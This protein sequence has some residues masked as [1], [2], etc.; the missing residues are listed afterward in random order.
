MKMNGS[1]YKRKYSYSN[2]KNYAILILF[3]T[4]FFGV[5][6][7]YLN[8]MLTINGNATVHKN[9]WDVHFENI[10][11]VDGS[12]DATSEATITGDTAIDF[13]VDLALPGDFYNFTVD[14][15]NDGTIDAMLSEVL[16]TGLT[17]EQEAYVEYTVTYSDG[18]EILAKDALPSGDQDQLLVSVK[19]KDDITANDLPS[20]DQSIELNL[21]TDYVQDDGTSDDR[22]PPVAPRY[23]YDEIIA[24]NKENGLMVLDNQ[25]STYATASTGID[26]NVEPSETNGQGVYVRNGTESDTYPIYYYR[27]AVANNNVIFGGYCW[28]IVRTT[29]TGGIKLIYNGTPSN[30]ACDNTGETSQIGTIEFNTNYADNAYVGY[31]Y[32][33]FTTPTDCLW[34]NVGFECVDGGSTS[35]NEAHIS[36]KTSTASAI[37]PVSSISPAFTANAAISSIPEPHIPFGAQSPITLYSSFPSKVYIPETAPFTPAIPHFISA[38]SKAGP[39]AVEVE[40]RRCL[41]P[42]TNSPFVPISISR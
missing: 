15:V 39:A 25:S 37:L 21:S 6:Y 41:P 23:L 8:T 16:K 18:E 10:V 35:Y 34:G 33:D 32:G 38:P 12:V 28:K 30:G 2:K 4:L 1:Y 24:Q 7:A 40:I 19:Y 13:T 36:T 9:T 42:S 22:R 14:V 17:A 27:G 26:F 20:E 31:M 11:K 29:E 3:I 5:G